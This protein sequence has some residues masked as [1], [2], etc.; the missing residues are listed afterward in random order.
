MKIG[1]S[2]ELILSNYNLTDKLSKP[3][4]FAQIKKRQHLLKF[5]PNQSDSDDVPRDYMLSVKI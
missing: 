3:E 2:G 5:I 4:L 1:E